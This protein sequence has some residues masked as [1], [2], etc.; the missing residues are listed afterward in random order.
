MT[1]VHPIEAESYRILAERVDLSMFGPLAAA[2][3]A[4][5][6]HASA[7]LEYAETMVVDEMAVE[8]GI[9]ALAD[10]A[11]VVVDVE[12]VRHG[13]SGAGAHC[14][15]PPTAPEGTTRS[16]A[17]MALAAERH[18][19]GAV[20]VVGCAPTAL[21]EVVRLHQ[22]GRFSPA[23]VIGLPV[24]FVGAAESKQR[25]RDSG[26]AAISNVCEKGGSAVAAAA[27]NVLIRMAVGRG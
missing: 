11:P 14:F 22:A 24:G 6:I 1:S 13:V 4:R 12:M 10:G 3:V 8:A 2:V 7:D 26:L 9:V 23:L 5:V 17:G 25:L 19:H 27:V 21:D 16:A 18:P 20:V 15:L